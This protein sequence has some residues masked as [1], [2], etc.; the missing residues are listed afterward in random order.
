M[1]SIGKKPDLIVVRGSGMPDA[2]ASIAIANAVYAAAQEERE[3]E[4]VQTRNFKGPPIRAV[5]RPSI[6]PMQEAKTHFQYV[7]G[8]NNNRSTQVILRKAAT[9]NLVIFFGYC[10]PE[11]EMEQ[12]LEVNQNVYVFDYQDN[13]L[14]ERIRNRLCMYEHDPSRC[15]AEFAWDFFVPQKAGVYPY[16]VSEVA[17]AIKGNNPRSRDLFFGLSSSPFVSSEWVELLGSTTHQPWYHIM[18]RGRF[19]TELHRVLESQY[20]DS[21]TVVQFE[22]NVAMQKPG[23]SKAEA[24]RDEMAIYMFQCPPQSTPYFYR[25]IKSIDSI[26]KHSVLL[27]YNHH[28][29]E[30][31]YHY[32]IVTNDPTVSAVEVIGQ[33]TAEGS[34]SRNGI[35][36]KGRV[37]FTSRMKP[38]AVLN[39]IVDR[40]S[41]M[42]TEV[43]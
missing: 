1:E 36:Y 13:T 6:L 28:I 25:N 27:M 15:S 5:V 29:R 24:S 42:V 32:V 26:A 39:H 14:S 34:F 41:N 43:A 23:L 31:V 30:G 40:I 9:S 11:D 4:L 19:Y 38:Q 18:E 37:S 8:Y 10:L 20:L 2:F 16:L 33:D 3:L 35:T 21:A 12:L 22:N 17:H 7:F